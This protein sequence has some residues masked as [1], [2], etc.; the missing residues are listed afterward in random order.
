[1]RRL[2]SSSQVKHRE[3]ASLEE[4]NTELLCAGREGC[5]PRLTDGD[6]VCPKKRPANHSAVFLFRKAG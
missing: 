2:P 1:M 5:V 6:E 3:H 4:R